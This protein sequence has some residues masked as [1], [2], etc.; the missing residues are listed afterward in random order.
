MVQ[1][2]LVCGLAGWVR[3][4]PPGTEASLFCVLAAP[5][6]VHPLDMG[7]TL[8]PLE[9][10]CAPLAGAVLGTPV[11]RALVA[12]FISQF[13]TMLISVLGNVNLSR[14]WSE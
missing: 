11:H 4:A 14:C 5:R 3:K 2:L 6:P 7:C 10:V 8:A 9:Q 12:G 13:L 1:E